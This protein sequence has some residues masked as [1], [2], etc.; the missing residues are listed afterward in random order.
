MA[1]ELLDLRFGGF[2]EVFDVLMRHAT[3]NYRAEVP[4]I[5]RRRT[6]EREI[7]LKAAAAEEENEREAD[8]R[9]IYS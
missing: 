4:A 9:H 2:D 1:F 8:E 7:S 5:S 6:R 3:E